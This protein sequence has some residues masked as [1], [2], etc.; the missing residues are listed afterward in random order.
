M[1]IE[2]TS[3]VMPAAIKTVLFGVEGIG[4]STFAS[5][6]PDP[7]FIDTE[8][9]TKFLPV[10]RLPKPLLFQDLL[11]EVQYV[12]EHP[13]VCKTLVLDTVDWAEKLID[14]EICTQLKVGSVG[15]IG[16][17]K[18]YVY[19]ADKMQQLLNRLSNVI[20][21]GINVVVIAHAQLRTFYEPADTGQYDRWELKLSKNSAPIVKEWADMLLF[22]N[23]KTIIVT[24]QKTGKG[25]GHGGQRMMF[26]THH[27][28]YDAKNR[29]GLEDELPFDYKSIAH[30]F[31]GREPTKETVI[32]GND[33]PVDLFEPNVPTIYESS[34]ED[35][36][37]DN[38][39]IAR[40]RRKLDEYKIADEEI[41]KFVD[42][43]GQYPAGTKPEEYS[44]DFIEYLLNNFNKLWTKIV[45][46]RDPLGEKE[47]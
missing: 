39:P 45:E 12:C 44:K 22:A 31:E 38:S 32:T 7:L 46:Q 2:I 1:N 34:P 27:P 23:Y 9:S 15:E 29:F 8:G 18:G 4:K 42:T 14:D 20:D 40:L 25:K 47:D 43:T 11:A 17:G 24:D 3:G 37:V 26:T 13:D 5:H 6:F 30:I 28:T 16:Y 36:Q 19:E 35:L 10:K 21:H 41:I 33:K